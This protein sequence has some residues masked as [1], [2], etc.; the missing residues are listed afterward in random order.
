MFLQ[1]GPP[2][3][4]YTDKYN[5]NVIRSLVMQDMLSL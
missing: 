2:I 3:G 4:T 1:T 5:S